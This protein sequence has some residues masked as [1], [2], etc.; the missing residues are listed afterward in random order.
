MIEWKIWVEIIYEESIS[1]AFLL[2]LLTVSQFR[3]G[4]EFT[5][6]QT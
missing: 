1:F 2:Y 3:S 5:E 4:E 6:A